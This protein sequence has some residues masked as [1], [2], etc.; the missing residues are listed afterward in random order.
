VISW[1]PTDD[2]TE[3]NFDTEL[4]ERAPSSPPL[5]EEE[6]ESE[7]NPKS[8]RPDEEVEDP[9]RSRIKSFI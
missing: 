9:I 5:D 4:S 6:I 1:H 8:F 7:G 3:S 2:E